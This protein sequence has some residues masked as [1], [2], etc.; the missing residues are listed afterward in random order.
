MNVHFNKNR[1]VIQFLKQDNAVNIE[2]EK[3]QSL[4]VRPKKK[5]NKPKKYSRLDDTKSSAIHHKNNFIDSFSLI[6]YHVNKNIPQSLPLM[7]HSETQI[8]H[9]THNIANPISNLKES[10][11]TNPIN[12]NVEKVD[13]D[14]QKQRNE[15]MKKKYEDRLTVKEIEKSKK[16]RKRQRTEQE[17][18]NYDK[19]PKNAKLLNKIMLEDEN[20]KLLREKKHA[21]KKQEKAIIK[22]ERKE[23]RSKLKINDNDDN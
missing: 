5:H 18:A 17:K 21:A 14:K 19:N 23:I 20:R 22:K 1:H 10:I 8:Q 4:Y 16:T 13:S 7:M 11:N 9:Q 2:P 15:K 12:T 6:Q 3:T